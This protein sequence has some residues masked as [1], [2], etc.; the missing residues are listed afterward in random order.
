M[1]FLL[2]VL[3]VGSVSATR[4]EFGGIP[5]R[6]QFMLG[7]TTVDFVT[8]GGLF[9]TSAG[10]GVSVNFEDL[11]DIPVNREAARLDGFWRF[12]DKGYMDFGYVQYNRTGSKTL[13]QDVVWGEF[14]LQQ[15]AFVKATWDSRF[16]YAAYRHDFLQEDRVRISGSAGIS[17]LRIAPK[18]EADGGVIGPGG[19]VT[20]HFEK[21]EPVQFPVPLVGLQL[22]WVLRNRLEVMMFTRIFYL[23]YANINGGMR[24]A[25]ARLKWH[26]SKH[27]GIAAAFDS[28]FVRLKE[29]ETGDYKVKFNYDIS[30]LSAYLTFAF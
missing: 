13:V 22:D 3:L 19:P 11:F 1:L 16:P 26:F 23:N 10:T 12:S 24:E 6:V 30:G 25:T 15:G 29:Y 2:L 9:L 17:Y 5:D 4:A 18:L 7:G 14:T 21:G 20:G 8:E 27:V 28:T